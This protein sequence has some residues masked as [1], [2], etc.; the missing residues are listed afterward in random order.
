VGN[1]DD[2]EAVAINGLS[3]LMM[4]KFE[5]YDGDCPCPPRLPQTKRRINALR[6]AKLMAIWKSNLLGSLAVPFLVT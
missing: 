2:S 3:V 6:L 4:V 5:A 1:R